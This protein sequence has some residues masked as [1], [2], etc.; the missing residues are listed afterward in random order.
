MSN[1]IKK[2]VLMV[3]LGGVLGGYGIHGMVDAVSVQDNI[4]G[5]IKF[6]DSKD[7][8]AGLVPD[9]RTLQKVVLERVPYTS[10]LQMTIV[11]GA[12]G[13]TYF[14]TRVYA[15]ELFMIK[16]LV[17]EHCMALSKEK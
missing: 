8:Y 11:T 6:Q 5:E 10:A 12:K 4:R 15:K 3:F 14:T 1:N 9:G 17:D 13:D 2:V 7:E 16:Q